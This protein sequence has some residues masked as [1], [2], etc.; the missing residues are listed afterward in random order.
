MAKRLQLRLDDL[1]AAAHLGLF[2]GPTPLPGRCHELVADRK[3]ELSLDLIHPQRLLFRPAAV[4]PPA[5]PDGG[6]DWTQMFA[7][8][9]TGIEDTHG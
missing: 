1:R 7:V 4:P 2:G 5:R 3:G 6:L 8:E 9:I